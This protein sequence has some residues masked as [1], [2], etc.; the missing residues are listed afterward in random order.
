M[1]ILDDM[2]DLGL[3]GKWPSPAHRTIA[4]IVLLNNSRITSR[5]LL[6]D[7]VAIIN[8]IPKNKIKKVTFTD[9]FEMG[10]MVEV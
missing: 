2:I 10:V 4:Q 6:V 1:Y 9:L 5:Q 8:K 3:V 7:N